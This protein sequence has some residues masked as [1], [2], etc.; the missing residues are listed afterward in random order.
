MK[1]TLLA[2]A[3]SVGLL[4]AAN[5]Q[6]ANLCFTDGYG[7]VYQM[8]ATKTAAL[9]WEM[10]GIADIG[11]GY[12]WNVDGYWDRYNNVWYI[13]VVNP[14]GCGTYVDNFEFTS[15]SWS[16][17][18]ISVSWDNYCGGYLG[19]GST[20]ITYTSGT[21]GLRMASGGTVHGPAATNADDMYAHVE[22]MNITETRTLE[23]M[24]DSFEVTVNRMG[25]GFVFFSNVFTTTGAELLIYNH[26]G[27][28]IATLNAT[29]NSTLVWDG[30]S[31]NGQTATSGMY[32]GILRNGEENITVKFVK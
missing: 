3:L 14:E 23:E 9:Y 32:I 20:T 30:L 17:G 12:Y 15:T 22:A 4:S 6:A 5:T 27:Q 24:F 10:T 2:I 8:T 31:S 19:S 21:C 1:N 26:T 28:Q 13:N 25:E 16:P 29:G 7:Y 11:A 18:S